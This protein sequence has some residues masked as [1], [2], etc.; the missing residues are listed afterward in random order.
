MVF[1]R[2]FHASTTCGSS[3][4]PSLREVE[5]ERGPPM[6][7]FTASYYRPGNI[8]PRILVPLDQTR[9][10]NLLEGGSAGTPQRIHG[11]LFL[12]R[13]RKEG[14]DSRRLAPGVKGINISGPRRTFSGC[15]LCHFPGDPVPGRFFSA[16][17]RKENPPGMV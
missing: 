12:S 15:W 2:Y 16:G 7:A 17:G 6:R 4:F 5:M 9:I 10:G 1:T 8:F 3:A 14:R 13:H 11:T